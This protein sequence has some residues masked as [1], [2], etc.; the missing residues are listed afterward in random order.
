MKTISFFQLVLRLPYRWSLLLLLAGPARAQFSSTA[1]TTQ[2]ICNASG[3]QFGVKAFADGAGGAHS[4]WIDKCAGNN[5]GPGP[6]LYAQHLNA[7]GVSQL[8]P[9]GLR[10]FQT[11]SRDIF[12][13]RAIPWNNG[14]LVAWIQGGFSVGGDTLRCQYYSTAGVPQWA[15]PTVVATRD[16]TVISVADTGFN[17]IPTS[18]GATITYSQGIIYTGGTNFS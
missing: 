9:N 4:V 17:I 16:A 15:T 3:V 8:G 14:L 5:S 2:F 11:G 6:A 1:S 7:A 18:T 12:G 10:L 13:M